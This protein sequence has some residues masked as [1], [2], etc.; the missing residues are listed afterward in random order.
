MFNVYWKT[1]PANHSYVIFKRQQS[2][3]VEIQK[4][5]KRNSIFEIRIKRKF[6][7]KTKNSKKDPKTVKDFK[8]NIFFFKIF[9]ASK[10][11]QQT[12]GI[13]EKNKNEKLAKK[14]YF[15]NWH[16]NKL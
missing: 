11:Q 6:A 9:I 7:L 13:K 2:F 3:C 16:P 10:Q 12:I 8:E 1:L 5:K 15:K 4:Q 14:N